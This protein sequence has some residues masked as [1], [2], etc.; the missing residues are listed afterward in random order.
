MDKIKI[1]KQLGLSDKEI[2]VYKALLVCGSST[3]AIIAKEANVK[4]PSA[5]FIL[6]KLVEKGLV[7]KTQTNKKELF[8]AEDPEILS[9]FAKEKAERAVGIEKSI[10]KLVGD[11]KKIHKKSPSSPRI[12]VFEGIEGIWNI[13]EDTLRE[14]KEIYAFG[15][16]YE[17]YRSYSMERLNEYGK[18]RIKHRIKSY[19]LTD[20][21]PEMIREYFRQE[22]TYQQYHF[23]PETIRLNTYFLIYGDKTALIS[24]KQP[25]V[26]MII[27]DK[28]ITGALKVMFMALWNQTE[29]KNLPDKAENRLIYHHQLDTIPK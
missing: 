8:Q 15:S 20:K 10:K 17:I 2:E 26:G 21:H 14:K 3:A 22:F 24:S 28:M 23:L 27:E 16:G 1:L 4:R 29:N 19:V 25:P 5:Y 12:K 9:R 6:E 13:A 7:F 18:Q 11:L